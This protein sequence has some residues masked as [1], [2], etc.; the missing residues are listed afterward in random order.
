MD[1]SVD[2][3]LTSDA[4]VM[5][6]VKAS[7]TLCRNCAC[8]QISYSPGDR[9][10]TYFQQVY[11]I[12]DEVQDNLVVDKNK[13]K[14]VNKHTLMGTHLSRFLDTFPAHGRFLDIACGTGKFTRQFKARFPHWECFGIDPSVKSPR[15]EE[16][17]QNIQFIRDYFNTVYFENM[18]FDFISAHGF[19][20]RSPVLPELLKI[21]RLCKKGT[22][23]SV[24]LLF[25]ENSSFTPFI[26]D[27]PF[28]Y[29]ERVFELY[30]RQSGFIP[31]SKENCVSS[32]HWICR[33]DVDVHSPDSPIPSGECQVDEEGVN[34]TRLLYNQHR[35]WWEKVVE[36]YNGEFPYY[37]DRELGL[38]GAGL[39]NA[40]FLNMV[41]KDHLN[42]VIDD[43]KHGGV[44]FSLPIIDLQE[45]KKIQHAH[46]FICAR[47]DY[48]KVLSKKLSGLDISYSILTPSG[49]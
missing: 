2:R 40:I 49:K 30:L 7:R 47:P 36:N 48:I 20:N 44:F 12:S 38:Y 15:S 10:K 5:E 21:R 27:H 25:L 34:Q 16:K 43:V 31:V 17:S 19:L 41:N 3:V 22:I 42:W 14:T 6:D 46:A 39:Y 13:S 24:E 35:E 45:A 32:H 4:Q 29:K 8:I 26:W 9:L 23:L 28:M 11:N 37:R 33:F 1:S 18:T